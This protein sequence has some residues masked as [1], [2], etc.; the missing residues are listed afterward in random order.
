M[1]KLMDCGVTVGWEGGVTCA[2]GGNAQADF[3]W[4]DSKAMPVRREPAVLRIL[5]R[6]FSSLTMVTFQQSV[7]GIDL[8]VLTVT[9]FVRI[10]YK[11]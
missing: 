4:V 2:Q 11:V 7:P 6:V 9:C 8:V 5:G 10:D 1:S 3:R